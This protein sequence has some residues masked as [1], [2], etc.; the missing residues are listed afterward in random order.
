MKKKVLFICTNNSARSQMAEGLL[1]TL[2][3][4]RYEAYSAGLEPTEV[5]PYAINVMAEINIDISKQR[6]KSIEKFR[7]DSFDYVV[8][9]CNH[10]KEVCPIFP[11]GKAFLHKGFTDPSEFKGTEGEILAKVRRIRDEIAD[12]IHETFGAENEGGGIR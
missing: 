9:V 3:G 1:N 6:S 11:G 8:T 10:A 5:N 7:R 2:H 4:D 12:W